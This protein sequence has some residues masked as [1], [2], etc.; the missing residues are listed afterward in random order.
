M[1]CDL[2]HPSCM[3]F[4]GNSTCLD[5]YQNTCDVH[6]C[7]DEE[8]FIRAIVAYVDENYCLDRNNV[9]MAGTSKGGFLAYS[10]VDKLNDIFATIA[11]IA[12]VPS[13]GFPA[14]FPHHNPVSII[15]FHG[16]QVYEGRFRGS[17]TRAISLQ[18]L[19]TGHATMEDYVK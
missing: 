1:A 7:Y 5:V 11:P 18:I 12:S 9:H 13:L 8:S 4:Y 17:L 6:N 3:K 15:D 2:L 14:R 19:G 10:S 16:L